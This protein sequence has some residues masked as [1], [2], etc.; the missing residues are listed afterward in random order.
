MDCLSLVL[1]DKECMHARVTLSENPSRCS[2]L[3][4]FAID[5]RTLH[6]AQ[7]G[8]NST[9]WSCGKAA[10][11]LVALETTCRPPFAEETT[12]GGRPARKAGWPTSFCLL[13]LVFCNTKQERGIARYIQQKGAR[14]LSHHC[15]SSRECSPRPSGHQSRISLHDGRGVELHD[16][17]WNECTYEHINA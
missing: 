2:D 17:I 8:W 15:T 6:K 16:L 4:L 7:E 10:D 3:P 5:L 12:R 9:L 13:F 1:N 11:Q 14:P